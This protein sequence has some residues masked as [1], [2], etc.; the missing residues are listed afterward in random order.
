MT[1][2]KSFVILASCIFAA[3]A[4]WIWCILV[5]P[6][7]LITGLGKIADQRS[8]QLLYDIDHIVLASELRKFANEERWQRAEVNA[9]PKIFW[10]GAGNSALPP[11][12]SVLQPTSV[13]IFD[14]RIIF[15][16]G[17]GMSHFGVVVF[18][19]GIVG[20]GLKELAPGVWFYADNKR[21]PDE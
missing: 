2:R 12:I 20:E 1:K 11:S 3:V 10:G 14:D 13:I 6:I 8:K 19:D 9:E 16:R 17:G 18:R 4:V 5:P 15:E 7:R 21:I